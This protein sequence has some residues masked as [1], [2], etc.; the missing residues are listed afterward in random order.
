MT[1]QELK[2]KFP[3]AWDYYKL[4]VKHD[5]QSFDNMAEQ[6]RIIA[7]KHNNQL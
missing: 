5:Q 7:S 6:L 4:P 1:K 2:E 3:L